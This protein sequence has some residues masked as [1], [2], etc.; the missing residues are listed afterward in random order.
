MPAS[1][2]LWRKLW[3]ALAAVVGLAAGGT[4]ALRLAFGGGL[5]LNLYRTVATM[6]T[7][8][9]PRLAPHTAAQYVVVGAVA[10]LGFSAWGV[11]VAVVAGTVIAV[12]IGELWGG[13]GMEARVAAMRGHTVV[14]GG[15]R[16]GLHVAQELRR[17]GQTVVLVDHDQGVVER[18][19]ADGW[20]ALAT[21]AV[22]EGALERLGLA[23]AAGL[24]LALP[25]DEKN[26]YAFL[27]A[28]E[29]APRVPVV[30][31]AESARAERQL[32]ALGVHRIV[33]PT[34]LGGLRLARLLTQPLVAEFLDE[35][36]DEGALEVSELDVVAGHE[37][38]G[39]PIAQLRSRL[40]EQRTVLCIRRGG[41]LIA[42]PADQER[43]EAGDTLL[44]AAARPAARA[45]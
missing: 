14:L 5:G 30:A 45:D 11:V 36:V 29:I 22:A 32:R 10:L 6:A 33:Q 35:V 21:D 23:H 7:L 20:T 34:R 37:L 2:S 27:A 15:G 8:G 12:D 17:S 18:L 25:E 38:A 43:I 19:R 26:L 42:L 9:D 40:G 4:V 16:V 13:R 24:V 28:R 31:R 3:P 1:G 39:A 44:L 41:S